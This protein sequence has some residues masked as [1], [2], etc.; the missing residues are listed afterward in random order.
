[1]CA[2]EHAYGIAMISS[3]SLSRLLITGAPSAST[4]PSEGHPD[5]DGIWRGIPVFSYNLPFKKF[6]LDVRIELVDTWHH[7]NISKGDFPILRGLSETHTRKCELQLL[8]MIS[9]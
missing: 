3:R 8:A 5:G 9:F 4:R 7:S 1:M 6:E 2:T